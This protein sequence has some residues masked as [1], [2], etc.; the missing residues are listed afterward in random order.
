MVEYALLPREPTGSPPDVAAQYERLSPSELVQAVASS[1]STGAWREFVRRFHPFLTSV[2]TVVGRR[3]AASPAETIEDGV[4]EIYWKLCDRGGEVLKR[5]RPSHPNS[6]FA[7]LQVVAVRH[8]IDRLRA[9]RSAKRSA[10]LR[11]LTELDGGRLLHD[12]GAAASRVERQVLLREIDDVV[13]RGPSSPRDRRIFWLY[14]RSGLE[15]S[16]I[17]TL[18]GIELSPKGVESAVSRLTRL[19]RNSVAEPPRA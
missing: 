2:A 13:A 18:P 10:N 1:S 7:Y 19:V 9:R 8:A 3:F 17:A 16:V 11:S 5:F 14:Y 15:A 6:G 4:Q 12:R